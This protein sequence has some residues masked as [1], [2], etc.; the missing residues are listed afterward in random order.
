MWSPTV[1]TPLVKMLCHR[2][3]VAALCVDPSGSYMSTSGPDG[4]FKVWDLRMHRE[5]HSYLTTRP[6]T[7][8]SCSQ[9]GLL[10]V[11]FGSHVQVWRDAMA[12]KAKA[13]YM[14][15]ELPGKAVS[16]GRGLAWRPYEDALVVANDLVSR[17]TSGLCLIVRR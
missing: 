9:R 3:P 8:L 17:T 5:L 4:G 12:S 10:G 16:G 15:Y 13:P 2:G 11:G 6:V 7:S 1:S 14:R